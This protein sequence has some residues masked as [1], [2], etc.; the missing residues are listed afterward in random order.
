MEQNIR[1]KIYIFANIDIS[2]SIF[3]I[4]LQC[5]NTLQEFKVS[6]TLSGLFLLEHHAPVV[7][8]ERDDAT[9]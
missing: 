3:L 4:L 8:S 5:A 6:K 7:R 9:V 1:T 2:I